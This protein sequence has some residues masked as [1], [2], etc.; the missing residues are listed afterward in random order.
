MCD[1]LIL[2]LQI[3]FADWVKE[4]YGHPVLQEH[5]VQRA[6]LVDRSVLFFVDDDAA[7]VFVFARQLGESVVHLEATVPWHF[8]RFLYE[9]LD[10]GGAS[11]YLRG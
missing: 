10:D 1:E 2:F 3:L 8:E 4:S 9:V 11:I 5:R 6:L 7:G